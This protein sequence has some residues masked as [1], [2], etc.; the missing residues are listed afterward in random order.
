MVVK[1]TIKL[2]DEAIIPALLLI[3]S[4][5]VGLFLVNYFLN[6]AFEINYRGFL[7]FLPSIS[8]LSTQNYILAENY[9]NLAMLASCAAGTLYIIAKAH[10]LH[11]SHI[12]PKLQQK[13]ATLNL[14]KLISTNL[15][16]YHQAAIW[17]LFLWLITGFLTISTIF[18][19]TYWQITALS[20]FIAVNSSWLIFVDIQ[21][22]IEIARD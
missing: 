3:V 16:L 1:I 5:I 22:E 10:F 15:R 14:E 2:I 20:A 12:A 17:L 8:Y 19:V 7:N 6:L 13:L 4:K 21:K 11:D 9:S 18:G